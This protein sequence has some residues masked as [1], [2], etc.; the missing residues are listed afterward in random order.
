MIKTKLTEMLEI[1]HPIIQAGMGPYNTTKL[2][3][4]VSNAGGLGIISSIG[5]GVV[6]LGFKPLFGFENLSPRE[7][8]LSSIDKVKNLTKDSQGI[9]GINVPVAVEFQ[10][11]AGELI[12]AALEARETDSEIAKRLKVVITSAGNPEPYVESIK[13]SG[14][15]HFHVV[16]SPYHAQKVEKMGTDIVIA[17]GHEGGGHVAY[18]PVHTMVLL[19]AVVRSVK[20]PVV[21]AGGFCDGTTL[22]AALALGAVGIQMGTRFIATQESEFLSSYKNYIRDINDTRDTLVAKGLFGNLRYLK[23]PAVLKMVELAKSGASEEEQFNFEIQSLE[24]IEAGDVEKSAMP[25]GEVAGRIKEIPRV[26]DL[27]EGIVKEA[28]EIIKVKLPKLIV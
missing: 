19:P 8:M 14:A 9:F 17:S 1:K 27:V 25:G 28:E 10:S 7:Q 18:D 11:V 2:S 15:F 3:A 4:A 5:M 21:G 12:N 16:P 20:I 6:A 22:A 13:E 24:A 23:N 26:K